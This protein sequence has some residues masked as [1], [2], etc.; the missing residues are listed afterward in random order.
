[1]RYYEK[2]ISQNYI[3]KEDSKMNEQNYEN[4]EEV[5]VKGKPSFKKAGIIAGIA[6]LVGV[7]AFTISKKRKAKKAAENDIIDDVL[8]EESDSE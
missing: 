8:I 5:A 2:E 1:M 7:A 3:L 4:I 6:T